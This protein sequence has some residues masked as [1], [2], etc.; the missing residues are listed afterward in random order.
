MPGGLM[1]KTEAM[2][3]PG[4]GSKQLE[5]NF[6]QSGKGKSAICSPMKYH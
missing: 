3:K 1:S 2:F 5:S 6:Y 4:P